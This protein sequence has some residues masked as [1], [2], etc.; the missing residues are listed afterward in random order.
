METVSQHR[1]WLRIRSNVSWAKAFAWAVVPTAAVFL[2][3][4]RHACW[5]FTHEPKDLVL[6]LYVFLW[7]VAFF[8]VRVMWR[9]LLLF[10]TLAITLPT[11]LM[12]GIPE[13]NAGV[14][15]AA[16]GALHQIDLSLH[17]YNSKHQH[18]YPEVLPAVNLPPV[19]QKFYRF[20]YVPNRSAHGQIIGYI[21]QAIPVRRDCDFY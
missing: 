9:V 21:V 7:S 8:T 3:L 14:E 19:A 2:G 10:I 5:L 6:W 11:L 20:E 15:S 12:N 4:N 1:S 13:R 17:T 18:W 16:V